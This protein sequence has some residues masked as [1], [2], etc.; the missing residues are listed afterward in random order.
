MKNVRL[1]KTQSSKVEQP[2]YFQSSDYSAPL[3]M[4]MHATR[5]KRFTSNISDNEDTCSKTGSTRFSNLPTNDNKSEIEAPINV[6]DEGDIT[7]LIMKQS[8]LLALQSSVQQSLRMIQK[9]LKNNKNICSQSVLQQ[10]EIP[11]DSYTSS[12]VPNMAQGSMTRNMTSQIMISNSK[13]PDKLDEKPIQTVNKS[14]L[15]TGFSEYK[16]KVLPRPKLPKNPAYVDY[17]EII[18]DFDS[19]FTRQVTTPNKMSAQSKSVLRKSESSRR[20]REMRSN[21]SDRKSDSNTSMSPSKVYAISNATKRKNEHTSYVNCPVPK[22]RSH[23]PSMFRKTKAQELYKSNRS[24]VKPVNTKDRSESTAYIVH[25]N[26]RLRLHKASRGVTM[27]HLTNL[28]AR[29][30]P[31][32]RQVM[33]IF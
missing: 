6:D 33:Q 29:S 3:A 4:K 13:T 18:Q 14:N 30:T 31:E 9:R 7:D 1:E 2:T 20:T 15:T 24:S 11:K 25:E 22:H 12:L 17:S 5:L 16:Q 19:T 32:I 8:E 26:L 23:T 21:A 10:D 28:C 27:K